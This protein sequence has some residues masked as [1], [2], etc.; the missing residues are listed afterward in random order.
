MPG[1]LVEGGAQSRQIPGRRRLQG[2]AGDD[3]LHV[4]HLLKALAQL[5]PLV[6]LKQGGDGVLAQADDRLDGGWRIQ[7]APQQAR[8]HG[9]SRAVHQREQGAGFAAVRAPVNLQVAAAVG[10]EPEELALRH[11]RDA[12]DVGQALAVGGLGVLQYGGGGADGRVVGRQAEAAQVGGA[13]VLAQKAKAKV[14]IEAQARPAPV[15]AGRPTP[16]VPLA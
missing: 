7:P 4:P 6:G 2:D 1:D 3:A 13:Q 5:V 11:R 8:S 10:I 15:G 16:P 9:G 14:R 12:I